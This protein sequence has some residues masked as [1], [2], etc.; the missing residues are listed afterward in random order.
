MSLF[1][2]VNEDFQVQR[3]SELIFLETGVGGETLG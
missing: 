3:D 1:H 2:S